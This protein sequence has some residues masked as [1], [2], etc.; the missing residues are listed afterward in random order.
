MDREASRMIYAIDPGPVNCGVV[1]AAVGRE[2]G[3]HTS[4]KRA[5]LT[6]LDDVVAR[7]LSPEALLAE[8]DAILVS[9]DVVVIEG[10]TPRP[11]APRGYWS[12]TLQ[13]AEVIGAV[14]YIARTRG[15]K[16]IVQ[17]PNVVRGAKKKTGVRSHTEDARLHYQ[18]YVRSLEK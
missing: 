18:H 9:S 1:T 4:I 11:R 8:L 17:N 10:V 3:S 13:I 14:K 2:S 5:F 12:R 7:V 15:A 16:V 6:K